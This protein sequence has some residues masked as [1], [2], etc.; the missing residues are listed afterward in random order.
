MYFTAA[1][2]L[3]KDS[4]PLAVIL[5][6]TPLR[7]MKNAIFWER[8][9]KFDYLGPYQFAEVCARARSYG[10]QDIVSPPSFLQIDERLKE[11]LMPRKFPSFFFTSLRDSHFGKR[12]QTNRQM[13][14]DVRQS[15]GYHWFGKAER[16]LA[17]DDGTLVSDFT[18][19]RLLDEYLEST[20][21]LLESK[22]VP[23][24]FIASPCNEISLRAY[25]PAFVSGY[26]NYLQSIAKKHS[27]FH[28]IGPLL[29]SLT[30]DWFGDASHLNPAGA[31]RWSEIVCR[32]LNEVNASGAPFIP[33]TRLLESRS[34][35]SS[36][37]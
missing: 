6:I 26:E 16:T 31:E 17:P 10:D 12:G 20:L 11:F 1:L 5:S 9:A 27:G 35:Q 14:E 24:Y 13:Y 18:P 29:R 15:R 19:T 37:Q 4:R 36:G 33:E 23:V 22:G 2:A 25:K 28:I 21:T 3:S 34:A 32:M 7:L 30:P 8:T